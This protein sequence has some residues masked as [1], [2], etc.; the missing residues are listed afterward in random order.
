MRFTVDMCLTRNKRLIN[1]WN[2]VGGVF[3]AVVKPLIQHG[4]ASSKEHHSWPS[5]LHVQADLKADLKAVVRKILTLEWEE[6]KSHDK[7]AGCYC[8]CHSPREFRG[9]FGTSSGMERSLL[10]KLYRLKKPW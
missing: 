6:D 4:R 2:I 5:H 8:P 10:V 7:F 3:A 9:C 1:G